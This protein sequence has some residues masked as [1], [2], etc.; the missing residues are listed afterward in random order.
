MVYMG[1]GPGIALMVATVG[2]SERYLIDVANWCLEIIEI[3]CCVVWSLALSR[4]GEVFPYVPKIISDEE[5]ARREE[6]HQ[7]VFSV[8]R[9]EFP[10]PELISKR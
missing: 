4:A 5:L 6:A 10:L 2:K 3:C 1:V 7:A 9:E 8:L